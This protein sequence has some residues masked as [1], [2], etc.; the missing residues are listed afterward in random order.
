MPR[1]TTRSGTA[2]SPPRPRRRPHPRRQRHRP[3][4]PPAVRVRP[5]PDLVCDRA[6]GVRANRL[7]A[8]AGPT[9]SPGPPLGTQTP[10]AAAV[11]DR[12]Q[13]RPPRPPNQT[14]PRRQRPLGRSAGHRAGPPATRLTSTNTTPTTRERTFTPGRGTRQNPLT[15]RPLAPT[16]QNRRKSTNPK[17]IKPAR[18][19][20]ARS[21]L[22][23]ARPNAA[24]TSRGPAGRLTT[25]QPYAPRNSITYRPPL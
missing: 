12:W 19:T 20:H 14:P 21:G 9:Q 17:P 6:I 16:I 22:T 11:F 13:T 7:A 4:Q 1:P 24:A 15:G 10:T 5:E 23:P 3:G 2:A 25:A 18:Q 8:D